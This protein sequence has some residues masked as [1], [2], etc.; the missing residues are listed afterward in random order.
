MTNGN[1]LASAFEHVT[2]LRLDP[3]YAAELT[4]GEAQIAVKNLYK[5][6]DTETLEKLTLNQRLVMADIFYNTGGF[7]GFDKL[8]KAV[9]THDIDKM[10]KES[11][12]VTKNLPNGRVERNWERLIHNYMLMEDLSSRQQ[13][14][15]E[16]AILFKDKMEREATTPPADLLNEI[17]KLNKDKKTSAAESSCQ[18]PVHVRAHMRDGTRI[19]GYDRNC[20][21]A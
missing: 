12:V 20:P 9:L 7:K 13:A 17:K 2:S 15:R 18:N 16:I 14:V 8:E 1:R 10:A 6:F 21:M 5:K 3:G 11:F 19:N 4:R